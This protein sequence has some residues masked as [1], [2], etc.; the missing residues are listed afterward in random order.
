MANVYSG[1]AVSDFT[2]WRPF[3][4]HGEVNIDPDLIRSTAFAVR[5]AADDL[6][7]VMIPLHPAL[8]LTEPV[9]DYKTAQSA[10]SGITKMMV[11]E[12][13]GAETEMRRLAEVVESEEPSTRVG[14]SLTHDLMVVSP[15]TASRRLRPLQLAADPVRVGDVIWMAT[16]VYRGAPASQVGHSARVTHVDDDGRM[17]YAFLNE[18]LSLFATDGAPLLD[19]AGHVVGIHLGPT[20]DEDTLGEPLGDAVVGFGVTASEV[21]ATWG[22]KV[23]GAGEKN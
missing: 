20:V 8:Q 4:E 2:I 11:A 16:A 17:A 6:P 14:D 5:F 13:F 7:V 22:R 21:L 18:R 19:D 12:A 10:R 15:G 3:V 1:P 9:V 23:S